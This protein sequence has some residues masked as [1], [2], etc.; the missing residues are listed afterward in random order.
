MKVGHI[1]AHLSLLHLQR[2]KNKIVMSNQIS[3]FKSSMKKNYPVIDGQEYVA[4]G[5]VNKFL[6]ASR[7]G[8]PT[9]F[10]PLGDVVIGNSK[11]YLVEEKLLE[12]IKSSV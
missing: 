7:R 1:K 12:R 8:R 5:I 6:N 3:S 9:N 10:K 4:A 11:Y 2:I